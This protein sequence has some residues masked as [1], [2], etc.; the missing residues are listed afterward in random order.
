M[1]LILLSE[2]HETVEK[3]PSL[4]LEIATVSPF[5]V[6]SHFLNQ[7]TVPNVSST[8]GRNRHDSYG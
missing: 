2:L 6:E 8:Y 3:P 1:L 5:A 4:A 7:T